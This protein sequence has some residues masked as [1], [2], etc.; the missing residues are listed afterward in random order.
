MPELNASMYSVPQMQQPNLLGMMGQVV[1]IQNAQNQNQLFQQTNRARIQVGQ[2]MQ[3]AIGP[4]GQPDYDKA[5]I[6]LSKHPDTALIA[7]ELIKTWAQ[8][9][10]VNLD[11]VSKSIDIAQKRA[12][13]LAGIAGSALAK[14]HAGESHMDR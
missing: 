8:L 7:P 10:N 6:E 14:A 9:K 13:H 3:N 12:G 1:G 5:A 11:N 2:I 4:D